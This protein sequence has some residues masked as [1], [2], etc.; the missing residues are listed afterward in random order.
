MDIPDSISGE[1][2]QRFIDET[3][4]RLADGTLCTNKDVIF[5]V[6]KCSACGCE[7]VLKECPLCNIHAGVT[8]NFDGLGPI[9]QPN[10]RSGMIDRT[11]LLGGALVLIGLPLFFSVVGVITVLS[12]IF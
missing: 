6:S 12:W 4:E 9:K 3:D 11:W 1:D 7:H 5:P 8:T 2:A 10:V